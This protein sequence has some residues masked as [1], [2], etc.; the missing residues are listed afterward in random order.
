M[1]YDVSDFQTDVLDASHEAPVLVDF[2]A[3]W[4][5][6]CQQ[7]GPTL[8]RLASEASDWTLV[9]VNTDENPN[10]ARQ[11]GVR[12][13]PAVKLF[14]DGSVEAEFTGALPEHA[15]RKWLDEHLPS[16]AKQHLGQA[17]EALE[18]GNTEAAIEALEAVLAADAD[19]AEAKVLLARALA[20]R[21]PD[22]AHALASS[23]ADIA[24]PTL[25]QTRE[26]VETIARLVARADTPEDLPDEPGQAAYRQAIAALADRDFDAALTHFIEVIRTNR[27]YDDDGARKACIS[28]FTLLGPQHPATK[29][30][31][32]TF[33]MALY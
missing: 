31:R 9:K 27:D 18:N 14:V 24:D 16:E 2:W 13:I 28:L 20:F 7:L 17:K 22:R 5:G 26:G 25:L 15:I 30:H 3:P 12:G 19:H 4:C 8:E 21:D 6:P 29:A 10:E 11:F 33:D 32:R 23:A 1:A